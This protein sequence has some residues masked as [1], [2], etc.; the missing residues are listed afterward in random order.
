MPG[1]NWH[2]A[3][4]LVLTVAFAAQAWASGSEQQTIAA[5]YPPWAQAIW[6]GGL[7]LGALVALAGIIWHGHTGLLI[8]RAALLGLAGVCVSYGLAF[9]LHAD[10]ADLFHAVYVVVFV[11]AF[12]AVNVARAAQIRR[13]IRMS[14]GARAMALIALQPPPEEST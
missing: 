6:Y 9:L 5:T 10:R 14:Q 13:E 8:E 12:A 7:I 11:G 4:L 3:L 1:R 2:E